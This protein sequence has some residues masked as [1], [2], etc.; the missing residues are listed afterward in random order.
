MIVY[1][2]PEYV[3]T[4]RIKLGAAVLVEQFQETAE[5][6]EA[7]YGPA[8]LNIIL[9]SI[10]VGDDE[11]RP[12]LQVILEH[13]EQAVQFR[14]ADGL[15]FDHSKQ[16]AIAEFF[17]SRRPELNHPIVVFSAFAPAARSEANSSIPESAIEKLKKL[18][19]DPALWDIWRCLA[20]TTFFVQTEEQKQCCIAG[21]RRRQW[22][23]L[24]FDLLS[25]RDPFGYFSEED[26]LV[27]IDSKENLDKNYSGNFFNYYR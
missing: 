20:T 27:D 17:L 21:G 5:F 12:R 26:F 8:P 18:I 16:E 25:K 15:N 3:A 7:T 23:K 10:D 24:Y 4:K 19:R 11:G 9:D 2:D 13:D 6:I 22:S 1:D 14:D